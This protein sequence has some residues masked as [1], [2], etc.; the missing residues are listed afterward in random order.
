MKNRVVALLFALLSTSLAQA[1]GGRTVVR[2]GQTG[3]DDLV[4]I[5]I[6]ETGFAGQSSFQLVETVRNY[7]EKKNETRLSRPF[8]MAELERSEF[9]ALTSW[10]GYERKLVRDGRDNYSISIQ[11]ECSGSS[12][13]ISCVEKF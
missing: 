6:R 12:A 13:S 7:D 10:N 8:S 11:D 4:E 5:S 2:C 1:A 9:P 3:F